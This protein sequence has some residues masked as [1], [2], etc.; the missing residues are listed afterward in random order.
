MT[1]FGNVMSYIFLAATLFNSSLINAETNKAPDPTQLKKGLKLYKV[2]CIGC[3]QKD[4]VGQVDLPWG[5][6]HPSYVPAMPLNET[7]HAWHHG[8][9]QLQNTILKGLPNR[10]PAFRDVLT[11]QQASYLVAYIKSLWSAEIIAC[12]GPKH[13][14]C[15]RH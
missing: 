13:M 2:H 9:E 3:H 7:S 6:R 10:M 14:S 8:D 12:Q 15:M 5:I 11:P 4:G 1:R